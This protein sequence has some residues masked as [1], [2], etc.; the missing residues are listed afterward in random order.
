MAWQTWGS[1]L[2]HGSISTTKIAVYGTL[3]DGH[4]NHKRHLNRPANHH[5]VWSIPFAMFSNGRFPMLIDAP[6]E[7]SDITLEIYHVTEEELHAMDQLEFPFGYG[8]R[9]IN[10]DEHTA[11]IYHYRLATPPAG[12][13]PVPSGNFQKEIDWE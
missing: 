9:E 1:Y 6:N 4:L 10:L 7:P 11:W 5:G 2:V 8:R 3:K 12:F 13:D